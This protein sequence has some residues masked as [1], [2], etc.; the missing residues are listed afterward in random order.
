MPRIILDTRMG[1]RVEILPH[2]A[3]RRLFREFAGS[4]PDTVELLHVKWSG[5]ALFFVHKLS[6]APS[7]DELTDALEPGTFAYFPELAEF[8]LVYGEAAPRDH[9]GPIEVAAVGIV[10]DFD[11]LA[12]L[13]KRIWRHGMEAARIRAEP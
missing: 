6:V 7:D 5:D 4:A 12:G 13:G 9:R 8:I 3:G 10:S 1:H 11:G 2:P